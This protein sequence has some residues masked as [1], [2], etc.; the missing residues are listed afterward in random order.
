MLNMQNFKMKLVSPLEKVFL[1]REPAN[2]LTKEDLMMLKNE[3]LSFQLSHTCEPVI[4][5]GQNWARDYEFGIINVQSP[6]KD[7]VHVRRVAMVPALYPCPVIHDDNYIS[8]KPGLF[9]DLLEEIEDGNV[10]VLGNKWVTLWVDVTVDETLP[11]G[12]Y[13]IRF[14]L[15]EKF[16]GT[17]LCGQSV[18]I[19]V[20]DAVLPP[21][22]LIHTE[23]F[24]TDCLA[25]YYG[26]EVFGERHW[27]IIG[28]FID[29]CVKYDI[30]MIL[31]PLF[32]PALDTGIGLERTTTQL[33]DVTLSNG[34]YSFG[35]EK[36]HRWVSMC[37]EKGVKYFEMSH[38]YS[39]WG[40]KYAPKVMA[41]V[42]GE[43]KKLFGWETSATS[44][45]Y[46]TFLRAFLPQLTKQLEQLG[47]ADITYF[48][49]SDEPTLDQLDDYR[50]AKTQIED[51]LQ[52]YKFIDA[53][54]NIDFYK[55]GTIQ[56]P[57][58]GTEHVKDFLDENLEGLWV[59]YCGDAGLNNSARLT[60][61]PSARNR[62]LG[63]QLYKFDIE[64]FLHWG[65]NF[66]NSQA[67]IRKINPFYET[68]SGYAFTSGDAYL[69]YPGRDGKPLGSIRLMVFFHGLQDLRA[70]RLLESLTSREY[71][72]GIIEED[73]DK[74]LEFN[75][76]P[77]EPEYLLALRRKIYVNIKGGTA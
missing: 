13:D 48:H 2:T 36:L 49:I 15:T 74:P 68:S 77:K 46:K 76:F 66:Y 23:W 34:E 70:L 59:Y 1:D 9:P 31:T 19:Q 50:K 18:T 52:N 40:A 45:E 37:L 51:L 65:F 28:N 43:Y 16:T 27:E 35:F 10:E 58:P 41:T 39:Q 5:E 30:N 53:L 54:S 32:T 47:I 22:Q 24:H 44:C 64:G 11:A 67:S 56:K 12:E 17:E 33:I 63:T 7:R 14:T 29:A 72:L 20:L 61:M 38:L 57:I 21:Q 55:T 8:T 42:D 4:K 71:V 26:V 60:A 69:V 62:I 25:D 6:I 3:T 75:V 73:L